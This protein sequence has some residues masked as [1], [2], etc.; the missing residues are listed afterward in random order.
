MRSLRYAVMVALACLLLSF[1]GGCFFPNSPPVARF[2]CDVTSGNSPLLVYFEGAGSYDS[3][4]EI[5]EYHWD[6][7]NGETDTYNY[8]TRGIALYITE[9]ARTYTVRLTVTDD[10]GAQASATKTISVE[11]YEYTPGPDPDPSPTESFSGSGHQVTPLFRLSAGRAIFRMTHTGSSNFII[12]L[13]DDSADLVALLVN[14]IGSFNGST[15]EHIE[16]S[17]WYMLDISA[18]GAWTVT[19]EQ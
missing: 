10:D 14:E 2:T 11:P 7:G 19:I 15:S 8:V 13:E 3:D 6:Y 17:G 18:D 5:V 12:W 16:D 9:V 4:G 1:V